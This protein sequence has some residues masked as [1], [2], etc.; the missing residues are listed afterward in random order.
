MYLYIKL[1]EVFMD[2]TYVK[3][4]ILKYEFRR[5]LLIMLFQ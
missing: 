2:V 4:Y 3:T 1:L 5:V